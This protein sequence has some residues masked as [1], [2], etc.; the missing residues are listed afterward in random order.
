MM[1]WFSE[2]I[3]QRF[4]PE[5]WCLLHMSGRGLV[6]IWAS[7]QLVRPRARTE[8]LPAAPNYISTTGFP[9]PSFGVFPPC[10]SCSAVCLWSFSLSCLI[11]PPPH[12]HLNRNILYCLPRFPPPHLYLDL[13]SSFSAGLSLPP[14]I[15]SQRSSGG[16]DLLSAA[17]SEFRA[18]FIEFAQDSGRAC[19][20]IRSWWGASRLWANPQIHLTPACV[21]VCVFVSG[22]LSDCA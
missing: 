3:L 14:S 11:L 9:S 10:L 2:C 4:Q 6:V 15:R 21:S 12:P 22:M 19:L 7:L 18:S 17:G 8:L 1:S 20:P 16:G 5:Q 13:C